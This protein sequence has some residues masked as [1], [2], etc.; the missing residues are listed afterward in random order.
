MPELIMLRM[1]A[2]KLLFYWTEQEDMRRHYF[3]P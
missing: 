1:M 3:V 2:E